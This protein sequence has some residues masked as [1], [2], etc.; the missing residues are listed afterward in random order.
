MGF[1][2]RRSS[3]SRTFRALAVLQTGSGEVKRKAAIQRAMP[4]SDR[5]HLGHFDHEEL[6]RVHRIFMR[7]SGASCAN[8]QA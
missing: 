2:T 5:T 6:V 4:R 3:V 1:P 8:V 7:P